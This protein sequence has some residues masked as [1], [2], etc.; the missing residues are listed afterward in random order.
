MLPTQDRQSSWLGRIIDT[1]DTVV[2]M[3]IL[4]VANCIVGKYH[5]YVAVVTPYGIRR[6]RRDKSRD[7]YILFNPWVA[8]EFRLLDRL[9]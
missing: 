4:P 1:S 2:T 5:M 8:G 3:G 7:L 6:T 9:S